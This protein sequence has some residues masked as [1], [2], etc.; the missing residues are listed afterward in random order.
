MRSQLAAV[1][2][3]A[4]LGTGCSDADGTGGD[5]AGFVAVG[6][7][8]APKGCR[9]DDV[10]ALIVGFFDAA[11]SGSVVGRVDEFIAPAGRFG[12]FSVEG[13]GEHHYDADDRDSFSVCLQGRVEVGEELRLIAMDTEYDRARNVTHIA[14]N[15]ERNAP[16][17]SDGP[18]VVVGKGAID[19]ASGKIMVWRMGTSSTGPP[20]LCSSVPATNDAT[21]AIACVRD[22]VSS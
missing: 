1:I 3:V 2:I 21:Q 8:D 11:N 4:V 18:I 10:G 5:A 9:P 16:E 14:Y 12:W 17:S 19:C 13:V 22:S 15:V 20:T 6:Q 7:S